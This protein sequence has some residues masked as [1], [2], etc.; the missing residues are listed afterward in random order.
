M[1]STDAPIQSFNDYTN[2]IK[3]QID[4]VLLE[5]QRFQT[6]LSLIISKIETIQELIKKGKQISDLELDQLLKDSFWTWIFGK[7]VVNI[8]KHQRNIKTLDEFNAFIRKLSKNTADIITKLLKF[9]SNA[10]NLKITAAELHTL[11]YKSPER[12]LAIIKASLNRLVQSK[13]TFEKRMEEENQEKYL[14]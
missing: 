11:Q 12:Q 8:R 13:E 5:A 1:K 9:K 3:G 2:V 7:D 14:T 10:T 4:N 6:T